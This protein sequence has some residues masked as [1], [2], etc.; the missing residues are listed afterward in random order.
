ME[1]S[2]NSHPSSDV[3]ITNIKPSEV[4]ILPGTRD[5]LNV[6]YSGSKIDHFP[7]L[8]PILVCNDKICSDKIRAACA[9]VVKKSAIGSAVVVS[10][11][12]T[13]ES[14]NLEL[15]DETARKIASLKIKLDEQLR[16]INSLTKNNR[17]RT[18]PLANEHDAKTI[19]NSGNNS[20]SSHF[21]LCLENSIGQQKEN[22]KE[23][24]SLSNSET[25]QKCG[26]VKKQRNKRN[27]K[28]KTKLSKQGCV[29][30]RETRRTAVNE[31]RP[32]RKRR[33][34]NSLV[35]PQVLEMS[36]RLPHELTKEEFLRHLRLIPIN[37]DYFS[38]TSKNTENI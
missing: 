19:E 1:K 16:T 30:T 12:R 5:R 37:S 14:S 32:R 3:Q 23:A 38:L 9:K 6:H 18:V 15:G 36:E 28:P 8:L 17:C 13:T 10:G 22:S 2:S 20:A 27:I 34:R 35:C 11:A 24:A 29:K 25:P 7:S 31:I 33:C 26:R 21:P 4:R